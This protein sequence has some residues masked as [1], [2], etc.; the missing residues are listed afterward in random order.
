VDATKETL[1]ILNAS[2]RAGVVS[3]SYR[4]YTHSFDEE[5]LT[6]DFDAINNTIDSWDTIGGTCINCGL[7]KALQVMQTASNQSRNK[8]IVLLTDGRNQDADLA[9][10]ERTLKLAQQAADRE[11]P[12][13]TAGFGTD[14]N[15][16][17]DDSLLKPVASITGAQYNFTTTSKDLR[18]FFRQS[19]GTTVKE[20][21]IALTGLS[22]NASTNGS[23]HAPSIAGDTDNIAMASD[24][25]HQFPNINDPT[26][27]SM[28][29][30]SFTVTDGEYVEMNAS[31]YGCKEWEGTSLIEDGKRVARC[32]DVNEDNVHYVD[33]DD[34][35]IY[36]DGYDAAASGPLYEPL[37]ADEAAPWQ[38]NMT[39]KLEPILDENDHLEL[40]SNQALVVFNF[41]IGSQ[42]DLYNRMPV[43]YEIG[44]SEEEAKPPV[45]YID[46]SNVHLAAD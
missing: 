17:D 32:S 38:D 35:N 7:E 40:N 14:E 36:L 37:L 33:D 44:R 10:D 45:G 6:R 29:R 2:D 23:V 21:R 34:V 46:I 42:P 31:W 20:E 22:T 30:H 11:I 13:Y 24:G 12:V 39:Q 15:D 25:G 27:P 4:G 28:F 26:A 41:S 5:L 19:L 43:L 16:V 1:P 8:T 18:E 3:Y 9:S